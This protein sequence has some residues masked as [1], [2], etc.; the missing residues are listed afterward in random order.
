MGILDRNWY[1]RT[2]QEGIFRDDHDAIADDNH[3]SKITT[4]WMGVKERKKTQKSENG[5]S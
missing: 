4:C 1:R 5:G 2:D 3:Q